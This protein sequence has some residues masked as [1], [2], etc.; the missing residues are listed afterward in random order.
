MNAMICE[1]K[2]KNE[3][4]DISQNR[5]LGAIPLSPDILT[6]ANIGLWAFEL[7]E[8]EPPRMYVDEAMLGLLG[9]E[10][11]V[12]PEEAYHAWYDHI[13]E[14]SYDLVIDSV[15][16][17]KSGEHAE[18]QYPWHHPNG[19]T[20]IIRCGG[21][22]NFEYKKGIRIEGTHQDVSQTLHF[23]EEERKRA[24]LLEN[25]LVKSKLRADCLAF[26]SDTEL[27]FG[28]SISYFGERIMQISH[29]DQVI[30]RNLE[31][32]RYILNAQGVEDISEDIC[33]ACPFSDVHSKAFSDGYAMMNDCK[34][35]WKG[36]KPHQNCP[37]KSSFINPVY[38][39]GKFAGMLTVHYL[40]DQHSF[41]ENGIDIMKTIAIYCGLLL[42]RI[43][44][45][46][47]QQERFQI[48]ASDR[49]KSQFLFN[50]S[51][52][53][54]T[55]LNAIIGFTDKAFRHKDDEHIVLESLEKIKIS[56]N[57]LLKLVNDILDMARIEAGKLEI[58]EE[59]IFSE[60]DNTLLE[61]FGA[62][63]ARK[64][65]KLHVFYDTK[66][67]YVWIDETRTNQIVANLLSNAI[68][69]TE[70]GGD[71]WYTVK[72]VESDRPGYGKYVAT[73]KDNGRG[74]SAEFVDRIFNAF[75]REHSST[76]S[77]EQGTGLGMAIVKK[78]VEAM[79]GDIKIKSEPMKG[80]AVTLTTYH[81]IATASEIKQYV[82]KLREDE[83]LNH[84]KMKGKRILLA[85]D[86]ELNREIALDIL[87]EQDIIIEEAEN[88]K[89]AVDM[90]REKGP[91][92]YDFILMDIQMPVMG[93]YD[94]T[95]AIREMY[96]DKK[97][98]IIALSANAFTEDRDASIAA[99]MDEHVAKPINVEELFKVCT[100]FL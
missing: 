44:A 22:R 47:A 25:E 42:E 100:K 55:P 77:G 18:V 35:G 88:G 14:G 81:R 26:I 49:A 30:F 23:D 64:R 72:Q 52:D 67:K 39:N 66:D 41:T 6:K 34:A 85:E 95:I 15:E 24:K 86:N 54:R 33:M 62:E 76:V 2:V 56:G 98:P 91:D 17:M 87:E 31:G 57:Y 74:M 53:I 96:P 12:P 89:V 58:K 84:R 94:A 90:L 69:Y 68:K 92:Y 10:H 5:N 36:I 82:A 93:G 32:E 50:M 7:D 61:I 38:K 11:Q 73:I 37:V 8:G 9:L 16:K 29:C 21:V 99:G 78:I 80:T 40:Q 46:K 13:D 75:E 70:P 65:I 28:R 3:L 60:A 71:I 4:L 19:H 97:I 1:T 48:E 43:D 45:Q 59:L 20:L 79:D 51:H 83:K 63:A 27:D